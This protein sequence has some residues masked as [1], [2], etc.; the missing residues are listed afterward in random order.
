[1]TAETFRRS[2][3]RELSRY[4]RFSPGPQSIS[5]IVGE[6]AYRGGAAHISG[7]AVRGNTLSITL[8][9][10]VG[11]FLTRISMPAFCP[12]PR[13]IPAKG[14]A[15]APPASTGPYYVSSVQGG[16]T[17]LLQNPNYR[18]S[19]PRRAARIVYTN[20]VATPTA[21]SLANAGAIDLLPQ[22]FDN[23]T[24]FFDPGGVLADRSGAGSAAARAGGQQYFLYPAPLLDYIVFNTNR[25]LF[26][27]VRLRRALNYAIDR[28]ALAAAFGDAPADRIVPPAVPGFPAGRVYP[29]NRPDLVT[30]RKLAG[31]VSRHAVL[32]WCG[33]DAR[34]R[35]LAHIVSSDLAGIGISVSVTAS[36]SCPKNGRYDTQMKHADLILFSGLQSEER[37]PAPFLD[38]ALARN[39]SFGSALG[40][41]LW[42]TAGFRERLARAAVLRGPTRLRAY[43]RMLDELTRA[44]PFAVFGSFI[45]TEYFSPKVGCKVFQAE[46][47]VVDLGAL[48]KS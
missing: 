10:P 16:R 41:G 29:L 14:Y 21:V 42:T 47:G 35:T 3:E 19:R 28:R 11:D 32:Y 23:T 38:Q 13:S 25:P 7:I 36:Q 9:K 5:D 1:M 15:T 45:W 26:R 40:P 24:S 39:G 4:N 34:Q 6:S 46:Y 30:A 8:V 48:C 37:D 22:D 2:I 20:D 17:V 27:G 44:A 31:R 43:V 33:P 12:V 18:G